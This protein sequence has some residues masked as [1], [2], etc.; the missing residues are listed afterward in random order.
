MGSLGISL[1]SH[2]KVTSGKSCNKY[3]SW[4]VEIEPGSKSDKNKQI[5][6]LLMPQTTDELKVWPDTKVFL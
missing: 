6:V 3:V 1:S 5:N 2:T 4:K